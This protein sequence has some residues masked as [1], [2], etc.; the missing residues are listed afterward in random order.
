[1]TT[2][3]IASVIIPWT[4]TMLGFRLH[5]QSVQTVQALYFLT[6]RRNLLFEPGDLGLRHRF[7]L[8]AASMLGNLD[9]LEKALLTTRFCNQRRAG[10]EYPAITSD[11][12]NSVKAARRL[13]T[14]E[15]VERALLHFNQQ[16]RVGE[17]IEFAYDSDIGQEDA[18]RL[19]A[20]TESLNLDELVA[21]LQMMEQMGLLVDATQAIG[22]YHFTSTAPG[23]LKIDDLITRLPSTSQTFVA[24]WFNDATHAAYTDGIEPAIRDSGYRAVRIDKKEHNNKIDDEIIAEIRRSKFLVADFTC[25]KEKVRGAAPFRSAVA[26][27]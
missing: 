14:A 17:T 26:L 2:A 25:E 22:L 4:N 13:T 1:M 8:A 16:V 19:M 9:I 15:R 10:I 6:Q 27:Q 3:V 12:I 5:H 11:V 21:F 18:F 24:M 20:I 7:P 23:W